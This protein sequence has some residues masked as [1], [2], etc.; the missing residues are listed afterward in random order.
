MLK[1]VTYLNKKKISTDSILLINLTL[2]FFP[3]SFILGNLIINLNLVLFC[4]LGIF[5]LRSEILTTKYNLS[6]KIIFLLFFLIFFS[7]SL[8]FIKF[9]YIE[10]YEYVHL[11]RLVKS[12]IFFRY[13]LMLLIIYLLNEHNILNFKYLF[14]S[15]AFS[16]LLIALDVIYQHIFGFNLI[17]LRSEDYHNSSFFGDE[18]ISG[19]YLQN[20]S[21]FLIFFVFF[22]LRSKSNLRF[23]L[24]TIT[25]CIIGA[26]IMLSGNKMPLFLFVFGLFLV[27]LFDNRLRKIIPVSLMCCFLLFKFILSSDATLKDRYLSFYSSVKHTFIT[28]D[29]EPTL[30]NDLEKSKEGQENST[31]TKEKNQQSSWKKISFLNDRSN[32]AR[33]LL[34]AL[35]TWKD[36]KIFGNG[37][38]S[39]RIDCYKLQDIYAEK[40]ERKDLVDENPVYEY[41]FTET[42]VKSKKNRLCST[43][44]HN[45]YFEILT[46]TGIVGLFVTLMIASLFIVF[47]LKNFKFFKG[48]NIE[49]FILLAAMISLIL[50]TFPFKSTGSVFT[51][52]D[53]AYITL[54]SSIILSYKKKLTT[55]NK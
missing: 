44:P 26:S 42:H 48:N 40:R 21:L 30:K 43:H 36:N 18:H 38:K 33:L 50:E 13:F 55:N 27:F 46:E 25:I 8:S 2:A 22:V 24:T 54:I 45:Y 35:D 32:Q 39:F 19:G 4:I 51:T 28:F 29:L 20:F 53:A 47:I 6:I 10:G 52:N 31:I 11:A 41:N 1:S 7:T 49:N 17:G 3:I 34:A 9:L 5:H 23:I 37:I 12:I 16:T 15:A 14:S